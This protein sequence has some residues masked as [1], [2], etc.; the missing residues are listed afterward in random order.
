M[1]LKSNISSVV[2]LSFRLFSIRP[3][4]FVSTGRCFSQIMVR[5]PKWSA[6]TWM[7]RTE[8]SL[9]TVRLCSPTASRWTLS[10]GSCTGLTPTWTT[11]RWWIMRARTDTLSSKDCWWEQLLYTLTSTPPT[12]GWQ[13]LLNLSS[14]LYCSWCFKNSSV[15][16]SFLNNTST[17]HLIFLLR[18][19]VMHSSP[20]SYEQRKDCGHL[21]FHQTSRLI[22]SEAV[23]V[24]AQWLLML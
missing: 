10:A 7:G 1:G 2:N 14:C 13:C 18:A 11:L 22:A 21:P 3:Y 5:S 24:G 23:D 17:T 8:P 19:P 4:P 12:A 15:L 20:V 9:W 6:V 16:W